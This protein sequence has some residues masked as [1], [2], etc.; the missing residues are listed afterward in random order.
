MN[1]P[2]QNNLFRITY[3]TGYL[4]LYLDSFFPCTVAKSRKLF[5]L[6]KEFCSQ[7]QKDALLTHLVQRAKAYEEKAVE[8]DRQMDACH[9]DP[10]EYNRLFGEMKETCR[11]HTRIARNIRDFTGRCGYED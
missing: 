9:S 10:A 11:K 1:E 4:E 8:L 5:K 2:I 6:I 7:E 3:P